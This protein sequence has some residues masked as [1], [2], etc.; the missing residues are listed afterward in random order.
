MPHLKSGK[1]RL[2]Q[3]LKRREHNRAVKKTLRKQLKAVFEVGHDK[4]KS[5]DELNKEALVAIK[6]LDKAAARRVIHPNTAARKKSQI[7]RLINAKKT[8]AVPAA[9]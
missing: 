8:P 7:A 2:R 9:K 3:N 6:K 5:V 4:A 1:K